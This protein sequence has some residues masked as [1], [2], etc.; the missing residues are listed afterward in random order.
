MDECLKRIVLVFYK[1]EVHVKNDELQQV[2][3]CLL[4]K[5]IWTNSFYIL[6]RSSCTLIKNFDAIIA[7]I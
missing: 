7:P 1:D 5:I 2:F 4:Y 6:I 3:V